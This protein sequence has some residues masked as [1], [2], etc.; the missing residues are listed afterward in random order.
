MKD[1]NLYIFITAISLDFGA[2]LVLIRKFKDKSM[3]QKAIHRKQLYKLIFRL[4][5]LSFLTYLIIL[6]IMNIDS[7]MSDSTQYSFG[8]LFS[9]LVCFGGLLL[10]SFGALFSQVAMLRTLGL[11]T[12]DED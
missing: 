12:V 6:F 9:F 7:I 1:I 2:T 5:L 4:G 10:F 8:G 3:K 11:L